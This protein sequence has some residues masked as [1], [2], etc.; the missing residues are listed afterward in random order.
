MRHDAALKTRH[1]HALSACC[2][3]H[4]QSFHAQSFH[5]QHFHARIQG[6]DTGG[7]AV[8]VSRDAWQEGE[9]TSAFYQ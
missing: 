2:S 1:G 3:T 5:A 6:A 9:H 4:A 7:I 8:E